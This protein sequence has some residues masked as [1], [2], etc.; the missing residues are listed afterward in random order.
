MM[1]LC[2]YSYLL[3]E[4]EAVMANED[5]RLASCLSWGLFNPRTS[6]LLASEMDIKISVLKA[7]HKEVKGLSDFCHVVDPQCP[8]SE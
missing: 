2:G 3:V 7:S 5:R 6:Q 8:S 4:G 1:H